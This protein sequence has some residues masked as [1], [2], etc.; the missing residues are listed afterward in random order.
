MPDRDERT[1]EEVYRSAVSGLY[2]RLRSNYDFIYQKFGDDGIKI[3]AD[4]SHEYGLSIAAR[5][6]NRL[7]NNDLASVST[8]LMRI[9]DTV[10]RGKN[11]FTELLKVD[12]SR[13]VIKVSECPLHFDNPQICL[14]HTT[15]EKT[16]V[17]KLN[18]DLMY[19]IGK[20]IP[21]GDAYCEHIIEVR[22][23]GGRFD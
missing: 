15:M 10:G 1:L 7:T 8:Y 14:A 21:A 3:I 9:F 13:A 5:A 16:V 22:K 2:A 23:T 12:N 17:E 19:R 6:R 20:S 4:M 18:P 11:G